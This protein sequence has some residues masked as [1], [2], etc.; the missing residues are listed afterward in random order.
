MKLDS[1]PP[2]K[3]SPN[4]PFTSETDG[5]PVHT[6]EAWTRLVSKG[7][8]SVGLA[9]PHAPTHPSPTQWSH[10]AA[11]APTGL[12]ACSP[13]LGGWDGGYDCRQKGTSPQTVEQGSPFPSGG[14]NQQKGRNVWLRKTL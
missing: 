6:V 10:R 1:C 3:D 12:R 13:A 5:S 4:I 9:Q 2:R 14:Q 11:G 8:E 7:G